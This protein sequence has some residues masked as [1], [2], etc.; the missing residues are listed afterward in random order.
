MMKIKISETA[1]KHGLKSAY[2]LQKALDISPTIAARLWKGDFDKIGINTLERLCKY[3]NCQTNDLLEYP[4]TLS[5]NT[6]LR[7]DVPRATQLSN[8]ELRNNMQLS[9]TQSDNTQSESD[10]EFNLTSADAGKILDL[11]PRQVRTYAEKGELGGKQ[12]KQS[13][14]FFRRSDVLN[15]KSQRDSE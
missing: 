3:F 1:Q 15:F 10:N 12:G 6:E 7:K 8:T 13:H 14:W 9:N 11:S 4:L 5:G 2:A